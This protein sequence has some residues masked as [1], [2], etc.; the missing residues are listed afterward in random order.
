MARAT[1]ATRAIYV[2]PLC[3]K[4]EPALPLQISTPS[5]ALP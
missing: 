3:L 2:P 1:I 4:A 5:P